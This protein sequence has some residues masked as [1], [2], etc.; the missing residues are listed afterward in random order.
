[1]KRIISVLSA[2]LLICTAVLCFSGCT[3]NTAD[4]AVTETPDPAEAWRKPAEIPEDAVLPPVRIGSGGGDQLFTHDYD[5]SEAY[6]KADAV[7]IVTVG[8]YLEDDS[9]CCYFEAQVEKVYKGAPPEKIILRQE[10]SKDYH[11][12][13]PIYTYG[14]R[15][16]VF[17]NTW[18]NWQGDGTSYCQILGDL[19]ALYL[20]S[21]TSGTAY[22]IDLQGTVGYNSRVHGVRG[23]NNVRTAN[24]LQ[25][26][27]EELKKG[28]EV[29]GETVLSYEENDPPCD[30]KI[31]SFDEFEAFLDSMK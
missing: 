19:T 14:N 31:Y 3:A 12:R 27:G 30:L 22:L 28:D 26:L 16:L 23:V 4:T 13:A 17:L 5:Y 8:N 11:R 24:L 25:T 21:D 7:C 2:A 29:L 1:M 6:D 18:D 20:A 10:E 9:Y 15:L